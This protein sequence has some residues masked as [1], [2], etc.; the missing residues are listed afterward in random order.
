ML[1]KNKS[2]RH[3]RLNCCKISDS[4]LLKH[5][6]SCSQLSFS[7]IEEI[8]LENNYINLKGA[9]FLKKVILKN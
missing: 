1:A 4:Y 8:D 2:L 9:Q 5:E 6:Q 3:L 7:C